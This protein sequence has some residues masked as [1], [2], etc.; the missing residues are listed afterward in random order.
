MALQTDRVNE[1]AT[2]I[3]FLSGVLHFVRHSFKPNK[4]KLWYSNLEK[5][6]KVLVKT[7]LVF[8]QIL[9]ENLFFFIFGEQSAPSVN[10]YYQADYYRQ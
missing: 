9:F 2:N 8:F 10:L 1:L 4:I 6:T 5:G 7:F 3:F